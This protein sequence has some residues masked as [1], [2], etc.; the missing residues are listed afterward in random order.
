[1]LKVCLTFVNEVTRLFGKFLGFPRN[2]LL[3]ERFSENAGKKYTETRDLP[4][5]VVFKRKNQYNEI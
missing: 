1:M 2:S 3:I 4:N 5:G